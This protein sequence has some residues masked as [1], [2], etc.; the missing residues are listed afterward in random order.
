MAECRL[1][2]IFEQVAVALNSTNLL[3]SSPVKFILTG[4]SSQIQGLDNFAYNYFSKSCKII[5]PN[6]SSSL[7]GNIST[8]FYSSALGALIYQANKKINNEFETKDKS[9]PKFIYL[10]QIFKM[11]I[12]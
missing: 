5:A 1:E 2:D 7:V 11:L 10:K 8:H 4:G 12:S 9:S 6:I 3:N